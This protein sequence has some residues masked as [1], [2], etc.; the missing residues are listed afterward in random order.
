MHQSAHLV[1]AAIGCKHN[2]A[3]VC[4]SNPIAHQQAKLLQCNESFYATGGGAHKYAKVLTER[5]N[6]RV[7]TGDELKCLISGLNFLLQNVRDEC[8]YLS[9]PASKKPSPKRSWDLKKE[10][11]VFPYLLVNCGH[12]CLLDLGGLSGGP[13]GPK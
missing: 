3:T 4:T 9:D 8:Y 7:Q 1:Y 2:P 10:G 6:V 12:I 5:L 13:G 11:S